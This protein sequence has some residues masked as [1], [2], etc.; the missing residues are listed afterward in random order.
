MLMHNGQLV[1]PTNE[2]AIALSDAA[3]VAKKQKT[4]AA[5]DALNKIEFMGSLYV[6]EKG[7]PCVPGEMLE[8]LTVEGA[9]RTKQGKEA[10]AGIIVDGNFPLI[11]K[12]P[13]DADGLWNAK[14]YKRGPARIGQQRV[15]RTRPMFMTWGLKF[16]IHYN[17]DLVD[18]RTVLRFVEKAGAEVGLGDWRPR[19]GRFTVSEA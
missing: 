13:R 3:K 17:P 2:H 9:K 5:F 1:D 11:Y 8:A 4:R 19:F 16:K 18:R 14:F 7:H 15:I 10:K 6:D 12:G